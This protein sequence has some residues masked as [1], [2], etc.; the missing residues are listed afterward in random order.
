MDNEKLIT[1]VVT[2]IITVVATFLSKNLWD[3]WRETERTKNEDRKLLRKALT[4]LTN[5]WQS[6]LIWDF[7]SHT[8]TANELLLQQFSIMGANP[9]QL[10]KIKLQ[11]TD[12]RI[13]VSAQ[14]Q[15]ANEKL[16]LL[17]EKI[18][19]AVEQLAEIRPLIASE[20]HELQSNTPLQSMERL[21]EE[22][23]KDGKERNKYDFDM[24]AGLQ[25]RSFQE[26][27]IILTEKLKPFILK[28]AEQIDKKTLEEAKEHLEKREKER[29]EMLERKNPEAE[30]EFAKYFAE[31]LIQNHLNA[32]KEN[33]LDKVNENQNISENIKPQD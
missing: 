22:Q 23:L 15:T 4:S 21:F 13:I 16:K 30:Q 29:S 12:I 6:L 28:I 17:D 5:L 19:K 20:L 24:I 25:N 32:S 31:M 8:K 26:Y 27:K 11:D 3:W 14:I 18:D 1:I 33:Q 9:E 7:E 2:G 10:E